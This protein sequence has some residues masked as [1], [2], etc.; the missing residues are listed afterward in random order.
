M[1]RG[2]VLP[3]F[4]PTLAKLHELLLFN[5]VY[6]EKEIVVH[7]SQSQ[8][9]LR[10]WS[11]QNVPFRSTG[12]M[13]LS[14]SYHC[15]FAFISYVFFSHFPNIIRTSVHRFRFYQSKIMTLMILRY[16]CH[17]QLKGQACVWCLPI[18]WWQ[19]QICVNNW[20]WWI[21]IHFLVG[22][23]TALLPLFLASF[24]F[25]FPY[26]FSLQCFL[27]VLKEFFLVP[28][29]LASLEMHDFPWSLFQFLFL[30]FIN[31]W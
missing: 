16:H 28:Y 17:V 26:F 25:C 22:N 13:N 12:K 19:L 7:C 29:F 23:L 1:W 4:S 11:L 21:I 15:V 10:Q 27:S 14:L 2:T 6:L 3:L 9:T 30:W 18:I 5:T 24:F 20:T 8:K 31:F